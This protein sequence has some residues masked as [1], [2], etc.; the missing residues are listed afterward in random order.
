MGRPKLFLEVKR[1]FGS[2]LLTVTCHSH[3]TKDGVAQDGGGVHY[4]GLLFSHDFASA[5][6][7]ASEMAVEKAAEMW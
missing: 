6:V 1:A 7:V 3:V 4:D 2:S 5:I